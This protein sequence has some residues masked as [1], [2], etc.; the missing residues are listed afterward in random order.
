M[1]KKQKE[2]KVSSTLCPDDHL[3][4]PGPGRDEMLQIYSWSFE[5]AC[6]AQDEWENRYGPN[7][8]GRG[9]FFR[10]VGAEELKGIY[11]LYRTGNKAAILEALHICSL[12]SLPLPRWCEIA[13]LKAYRDVRFYN[14]KGWDDVFGRP[15]PKGTQ[16][17]A[18]KQEREYDMRV[19]R[20]IRQI[21]ADNPSIPID[22]YLF[23]R[24]G[25][26]FGIGSKTLT[27][28]YY[29]NC[30]NRIEKK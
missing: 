29:Y 24:I 21:K 27:E 13:F 15:H 26:E 7:V 18:R 30:K 23:E 14:A 10:W 3:P 25:R 9:P 4:T 28:Q 16:L 19:Y 20:R 6:S 12:N 1:P 22:G 5:D 17:A 11:E 2:K 8:R